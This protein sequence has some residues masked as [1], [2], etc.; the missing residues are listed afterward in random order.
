MKS[1][2]FSLV[3]QNINVK[4]IIAFIILTIVFYIIS[5]WK[6]ANIFVIAAANYTYLEDANKLKNRLNL[7]NL[8]VDGIIIIK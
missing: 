8:K 6:P 7:L 5:V 4:H 1:I 3:L 2:N